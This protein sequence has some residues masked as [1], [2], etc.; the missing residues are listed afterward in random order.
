[1]A[2]IRA[3]EASFDRRDSSDR[4][5]ERR[6]TRVEVPVRTVILSTQSVYTQRYSSDVV[7]HGQ[8]EVHL[9]QGGGGCTPGW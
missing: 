1:M 7:Q 6:P 2:L 5:E 8:R 4:K 9:Q 3:R